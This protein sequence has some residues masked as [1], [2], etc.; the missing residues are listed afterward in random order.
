M[1]NR[2]PSQDDLMQLS[3]EEWENL[4]ALI[5]SSFYSAHRVEDHFGKGNG[6]DS[7][8]EIEGNIEGWQ[9]RKFNDRLGTK[10][11]KHI[12]ENI[13]LAQKRCIAELKKPLLKFTIIFN[14]DPEP[15][16]QKTIGEIERLNSL[17]EWAKEEHNIDFEYKGITWVLQM[18]LKNPTIKPELF[19]NIKE[20]LNEV[21]QSLHSELFDIK[22][23]LKNF[24]NNNPLDGKLRETFDL[25]IRE[26]N[27]HY[28]RGIELESQ[29]EFSKSITSL[30]DA[31]RLIEN[32]GINKELEGK[33]LA[34]LS[35]VEVITGFLTKAIK[36]ATKALDL[37]HDQKD[38]EEHYV[39]ARGN[40]AFALYTNQEYKKS[41]KHFLD[42]LEYFES[43]GN[44]L[45]IVR[46]LGHLLTLET[47]SGSVDAAI[48]LI[49]RVRTASEELEKL[50]GPNTV[51]VSSLGSVAN[52]YAEIGIKTGNKDFLNKAIVLLAKIENASKNEELKRMWLNSKSSRARCLWNL[53]K[54]EEAEKLY[55]EIIAEGREFLPKVAI[56]AKFNLAL[57][58]IELKKIDKCKYLLAET[59]KE[60]EEI[61]DYP[62]VLD[63]RNILKE[64]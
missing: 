13:I 42:I 43:K 49:D 59:I 23:E 56:D 62:S 1:S 21:S 51:T 17:R 7:F 35:G 3:R 50:L 37:L 4:C 6:L 31:A 11:A 30:E 53:D 44:L 34:F 63:A 16:H 10:Q 36:H 18:L 32:R 8:R 25:L 19:E 54:L 15:G 57:L 33:I 2:T 39:F 24:L 64:L 46:T 40:L 41:K 26:A 27:T 9:F 29:E 47:H 52:L 14:I 5:C 58:L 20:T 22:T 55:S 60:Y 28:N 45:E 48:G 61:G 12:K 38:S